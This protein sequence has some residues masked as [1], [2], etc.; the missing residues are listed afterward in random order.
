MKDFTKTGRALRLSLLASIAALVAAVPAQAGSIADAVVERSG[1]RELTI[2]WKDADPVDVLVATRADATAADATLVSARDNDGRHVITETDLSRRY[3]LLR[4]SKTGQTVHVAERLVPLDGGSNFRDIGGYG[5]AD[6]KR[7][8]WG[9]IYRS[10]GTAMLTDTDLQRVKSLGLANMI[11]LR[12]DEE[13]VLAPSRIDGVPYTAVG[14]SMQA[15]MQNFSVNNDPGA[16]Y[17]GFTH[18]LTPQLRQLFAKLLRGE[19]PLAYNCS[20][21]Q[22]RTGFTTAMVMSALG[23]SRADIFTDY[24]LS[25]QYRRP[26]NELPPIDAATAAKNPVAGFFARYQQAGAFAKAQPLYSADGTPLLSYAFAAVEKD[27]GSVDGYLKAE[28][29]VGPV[30]ITRLRALYTE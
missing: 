25:T 20:A 17:R 16:G 6:G 7:V 29:G 15:I 9:L 2:R 22:D 5:A 30:E 11:D 8:R 13:R 19:Q 23:V 14:Y 26:A 1:A 18:S 27:Y 24:H 3:V 28:L 21:G 4:D 10:G 12:S